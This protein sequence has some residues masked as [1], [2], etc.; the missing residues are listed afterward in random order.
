MA[1]RWHPANADTDVDAPQCWGTCDRCGRVHN[2]NKLQWQFDYRGSPMLQNTRLLV[3]DRCLDVPN[4]QF[5]P[6]MLSPDPPPIYNTRPEPYALDETDWLTTQDGDIID[7]ELGDDFISTVPNPSGRAPD[8]AN[9]TTE[10]DQTIVT[11]DG[12]NLIDDLPNPDIKTID[13]NPQNTE[14]PP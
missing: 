9:M 4:L 3:C 1:Y 8:V 2:L 14:L 5:T 13:P 10:D 12:N 11:E 6:V 7:T